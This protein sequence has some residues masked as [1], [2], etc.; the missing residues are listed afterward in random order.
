MTIKV[1]R[2]TL[3]ALQSQPWPS[4]SDDIDDLRIYSKYPAHHDHYLSSSPVDIRKESL[5]CSI[6]LDDDDSVYTI[7]TA[8]CSD[9]ESDIDRRVCF[10]DDLVSD[11]WTRPYTEK[12]DA[13][14]L[15]Y[16]NDET[17]R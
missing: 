16:S 3:V 8:S 6:S 7:S 11:V 4:S 12:E 2:E 10:A 13:S 1:E 9:S 14:E 15:Y 5:P 17:Q